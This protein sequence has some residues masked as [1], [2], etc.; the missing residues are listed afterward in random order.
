VWRLERQYI[1]L[2]FRQILGLVDILDKLPTVK[3]LIDKGPPDAG[4]AS[5]GMIVF[6]SAEGTSD[7]ELNAS[8]SALRKTLD[9]DLASLEE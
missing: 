4:P 2:F 1:R 7:E 8:V 3:V 5:G 6:F 9:A